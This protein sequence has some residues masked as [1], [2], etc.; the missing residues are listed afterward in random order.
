MGAHIEFFPQQVFLFAALHDSE[1]RWLV[2]NAIP[3]FTDH[4]RTP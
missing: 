3:R 2:Q 4:Q 1:K